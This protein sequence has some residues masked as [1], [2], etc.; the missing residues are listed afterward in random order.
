M[1][2]ITFGFLLLFA[3]GATAQNNPTLFS[4]GSVDTACYGDYNTTVRYNIVVSDIDM[5]ST[6]LTNFTYNGAI[7]NGVDVINPPYVAGQTQRTFTIIADAG[8]GLLPGLNTTAI[9]FD[10]IG[11]VG[12]DPGIGTGTVDAYAYGNVTGILNLTGL[13]L[14][15]NDNPIDLRNYTSPAGG[16]FTWGSS[17]KD[18]M[19]DPGIYYSEGAGNVYYFFKNAAGCAGTASSNGPIINIP[20]TVV[21]SPTNSTCGNADGSIFASISGPTPPYDVYWSTGFG[22]T[23]I[24]S[25]TPLNNLPAGN[26]YINVTD[27]NG[28]KAVAL[29]QISDAEVDV[30]E[31]IADETCMYASHDGEIS[32]NIIPLSGT[33][34]YIY[35]STGATT[36]T[37]AGLSKGEY[38]VEVRTDAGCEANHSYFVNYQ[39]NIYASNVNS[40]DASCNLSDG[41]VDYDVYGGS[42]TYSYLW[43]TGST[44]SDLMGVPSGT[45][46]CVATDDVY[47]C[48]TTFT[49]NVY[50]YG[51]P[52]AYIDFVTKPSCGNTDGAIEITPYPWSAPVVSVSWSS[53][54]TTEDLI[55]VPAGDYTF[56]VLAQDGCM[57]NQTIRLENE[58]PE[59]PQICMLTVDTSLIYNMVVWEKEPVQGSIAGFKVYRE[60]STYGNFELVSTRPYA[61]ESIFQDND[62][63]PV[64]RS[65]RYYITQYDNCG[66]ESAPSDV[67]KTIHAVTSTPDGIVYNV[68]WDSYEGLNYSSVDVFRFD[69]TSGWVPLGN[70]PSTIHS[71]SETPTIYIGLDYLVEFNLTDPCQSSKVQDHNSSRSNKSASVFMPGGSTAQIQ[72]T[73]LGTISIYP[74][75]ANNFFVIQIDAIETVQAYEVMDLS[76]NLV[77]RGTIQSNLT[78]IDAEEMAAGIYLVKIITADKIITQKLVL[79]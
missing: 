68:H 24:S 31:T 6:Y 9:G 7:L 73:D 17:G 69:S 38:T 70:F 18:Y 19:F 51:S 34:N 22:E 23:V 64:D 55:N 75:P 11:N 48:Q 42:G 59:R 5:D 25:P 47:G 4:T 33:V 77:H 15:T 16:V 27:P 50:A 37:I 65:W 32:L 45:Y 28:C 76:G 35:W 71:Y 8:T 14:C 58:K 74:N 46:T 1:K 30:S 20:P 78:T 53:G 57:F 26:Y 2:N 61:L 54:Q 63:S 49:H 12:N 79:N 56:T 66:N 29:A 72:D 67:H 36:S 21:V 60:T 3:L 44:L 10:I 40:T 41:V 39:Y 52:G 13:T 43:N 62:A